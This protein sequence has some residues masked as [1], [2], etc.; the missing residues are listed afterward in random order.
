MAIFHPLL[1]KVF[2]S[3][4]NSFN[5]FSPRIPNIYNFWTSD[6]GKW[7]HKDV[8][9][10]PQNVNRQT[11]RRTDGRTNHLKESIG[12]EGQYFEKVGNQTTRY[13]FVSMAPINI[14]MVAMENVVLVY[15]LFHLLLK[16]DPIEDTLVVLI[17]KLALISQSKDCIPPNLNTKNSAIIFTTR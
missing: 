11:H 17:N 8:E 3:E 16:C 9:T 2:K 5:Y 10:V 14:Q 12:P 1:V 7:G 4:T 15:F 13:L 6:F